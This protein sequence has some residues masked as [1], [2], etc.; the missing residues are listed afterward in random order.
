M[1]K[2]SKLSRAEMKNVLGG[3]APPP[4]GTCSVVCHCPGGTDKT[5]KLDNC[6][7]NTCKTDSTGALCKIGGATATAT[8]VNVCPAS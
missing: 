1:S 6:D 5:A 7:T 4:A 2:F 8:C 3:T